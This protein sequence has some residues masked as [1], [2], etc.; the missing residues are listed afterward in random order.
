MAANDA[1]F[2]A[3]CRQRGLFRALTLEALFD[4]A[5]GAALS[6]LPKGNRLMVIS[7]SGGGNTLAVDAAD[8]FGLAIPSLPGQFVDRV[9]KEL[10]LPFNACVSNPCDL[11]YFEGSLF[12]DVIKLADEFDLADIYLLNYGD[13]IEN[14]VEAVLELAESVQGSLAVAYFG[15]GEKEQLGRQVLHEHGIPVYAT[16]ERAITGIAA[17]VKYAE[18]RQ[19]IGGEFG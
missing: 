18:Y 17:A 1:V 5:K 19:K 7:S 11:A 14:G 9:K 8:E 10:I 15:G 6:R 13:P 4:A 12:R 3:V 2:D 16:P